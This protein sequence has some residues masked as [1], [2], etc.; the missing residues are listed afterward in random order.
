LTEDAI[1]KVF[2]NL[3]AYLSK[4]EPPARTSPDCRREQVL[5]RN[6]VKIEEF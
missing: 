5:K 3:P 6:A 2:D 4:K 1:Q